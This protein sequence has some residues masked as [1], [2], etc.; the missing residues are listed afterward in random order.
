MR[1][2]GAVLVSV[3]A[4]AGAFNPS[5][6]AISYTTSGGT[7][8]QDFDTLPNT[9]SPS[10]T[11]DSTLAGWSLFRQ[12]A[13]GTAITSIATGTGSSNS[14]SF[15]SFGAASNTER[16]LGGVG[17]GGAYFGSPASAAV[18]GWMAVAILND[19]GAELDEFDVEFDGEQ[20]RNGGN[21]SAQTMVLEFGFGNTF[22]TVASWTAP[23]GT[24]NFTTPTVGATAAALDGNDNANRAADLG[25]VVSSLSWADGD[26]L[27]IRWV[28]VNDAGNDHGIAI[29]NFSFSATP[30]PATM[31]LL[32]LGAIGLLRRRRAA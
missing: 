8:S 17:S 6:A 15:Y 30:E 7:I 20:W 24:F 1:R 14:G 23:G 11:N 18:A 4:L 16:A 19:T 27:W 32:G 5:H 28:E 26:T 22:D 21:T 31:T 13:P 2:F 12:P 25:G 3:C 29:D 9:G 10:W